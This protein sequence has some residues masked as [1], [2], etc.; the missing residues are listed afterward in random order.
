MDFGGR[1]ILFQ[2]LVGSYN[3][4]LNTETSDKDYKT[5]VLPNFEDLYSGKKFNKTY[6]S[7][8]MD[9]DVHDI[10]ELSNLLWKSNVNF[11]EVLF[12]KEIIINS[13]LD[14]QIHNLLSNLFSQRKN[15]ARMNLPYLYNSC[16]G[17]YKAKVNTILNKTGDKDLLAKYG[18]D[19]K[20]AMHS[21]RIL[22]VLQRFVYTDF[23]DFEYAIR[24]DIFEDEKTQ[25][26]AIKRGLLHVSDYIQLAN[27]TFIDIE[28]GTCK[29]LYMNYTPNK[30]A[31][32]EIDEIIKDIIKINIKEKL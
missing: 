30:K 24:Y 17:M 6:V 16:I 3:Y 10:R 9:Y 25:L 14:S 28:C 1:T 27:K 22:N 32:E 21:L 31:K 18:Y 4:N 8:T 7:D 15:I 2:S 5:L 11:L 23:E 20:S 13:E 19:T 26:L 29:N 12:S